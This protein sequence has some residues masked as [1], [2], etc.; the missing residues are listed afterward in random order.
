MIKAYFGIRPFYPDR[1][2][3]LPATTK[4]WSDGLLRRIARKAREDAGLALNAN[5]LVFGEEGVTGQ[6]I[7]NLI[8]A[9]FRLHDAVRGV[10]RRP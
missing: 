5:G 7:A 1:L 4:L 9:P 2:P 6:R 10:Q 8:L 3:I